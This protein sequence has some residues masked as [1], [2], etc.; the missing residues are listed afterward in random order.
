MRL[1]VIISTYNQPQWLEK[2]VW[3]YT[4]QTYR[5]FE[6]VIADDGSAE[7]TGSTI[8]RLRRETGLIIRHLWHE[9]QG[10]RKCSIMNRAIVE[11]GA[12]YLVFTDGDCIPR[13]DFLAQHA[14]L[15]RPGWMLSGGAV[16][17]PVEISRRITKDD[18]LADRATNIVWLR[19]HGLPWNRKQLKLAISPRLGT[20]ADW[21][22]P[23]K[24]TWNGG[25]AST[26]KS[27]LLRGNGFDERMAYGGEDR[28]LG[29][30]L[31]NSGLRTKGIR[32]RAI[33]VHLDHSRGYVRE[34][35]I[36]R[37]QE[38]RSETRAT[39]KVWTEYGIVKR[40]D[41]AEL[42]AA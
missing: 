20:F 9:D 35:A 28:E 37:N 16:R 15:A 36:R 14:R 25:N 41:A 3:G 39:G 19:S 1:S 33:C 13:C 34:E 24:A 7:E 32:Y 21:I 31:I 11:A 23:T 29:E 2:V 18:I 4:A 40:P 8:D 27:N 10:F 6:L 22:T 5:D 26:W 12:E 42:Q 17:L 30:R 38:I